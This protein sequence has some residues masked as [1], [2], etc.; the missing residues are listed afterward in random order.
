MSGL[1]PLH[2]I[3]T[4]NLP[5]ALTS[6]ADSAPIL[7]SGPVISICKAGLRCSRVAEMAQHSHL[8]YWSHSN[9]V[10]LALTSLIPP[11]LVEYLLCLSHSCSMNMPSVSSPGPA[12]VS[13]VP[14]PFPLL[15][16][17]LL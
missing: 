5:Q 2:P 15:S 4:D 8:A 9:L 14:F 12:S 13:F 6:L 10:A 16:P 7:G 11:S 17:C 1:K 3:Q